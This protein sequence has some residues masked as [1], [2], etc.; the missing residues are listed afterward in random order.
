VNL[1]FEFRLQ[2][3]LIKVIP[4]TLDLHAY[5]DTLNKKKNKPGA[6]FTKGR[7]S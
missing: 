7:Q 6:S 2:V 1:S 3:A 5:I 4:A